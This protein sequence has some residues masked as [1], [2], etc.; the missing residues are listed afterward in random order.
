[1]R[2]E[3]PLLLPELSPID[4]VVTELVVVAVDTFAAGAWMCA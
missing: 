1:M 4:E 3:F 2:P